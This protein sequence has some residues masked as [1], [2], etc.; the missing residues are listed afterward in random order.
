MILSGEE[1]RRRAILRPYHMRTRTYRGL[2]FG[3]SPA[4][5]DVRIEQEVHLH[6]D[7]RFVLASI[8]EHIIM[9]DDV[10]GIVHDKSSWARMG[11]SVFNTVIEPGWNGWLTIELAFHADRGAPDVHILPGDPIAQIIFHQIA[12]PVAPYEGTYQL[13]AP[14]VTRSVL[15]PRRGRLDG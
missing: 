11:L 5:Y 6:P 1:I 4:G 15:D 7:H 9:P 3:E 12:G 10:L 8:M 14:G 2:S 13:Q